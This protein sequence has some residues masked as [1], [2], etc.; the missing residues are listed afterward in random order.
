[1]LRRFLALTV[2]ALAA[3]CQAEQDQPE[4]NGRDSGSAG[5]KTAKKAA[6]KAARYRVWGRVTSEDG[7]PVKGAHI[8]LAWTSMQIDHPTTTTDGNG[9]YRFDGVDISG[10]ILA[11]QAEGYAPD[12]EHL[13]RPKDAKIDFKL[14]P[15]NWL[16]GRIVNGKDEPISGVKVFVMIRSPKIL[17]CDRMYCYLRSTP[18]TDE[19][20][21][22]RLQDLPAE[23]VF[24]SI[25]HEG[26]SSVERRG[27]A[28][29]RKDNLIQLL[30][31]G[32][33]S[34]RVVRAAD[35]KP[36]QQFKVRLGFPEQRLRGDRCMSIPSELCSPGS[37]FDSPDGT[38]VVP[39]LKTGDTVRVV[40]DAPGFQRQADDRVKVQPKSGTDREAAAA[41]RLRRAVDFEGV[42]GDAQTGKGLDDVEVVLLDAGARAAGQMSWPEGRDRERNHPVSA[43]TDA[44][45][46]FRIEVAPV[47]RGVV[48]LWKKG[49]ARTLLRDVDTSRSL[50]ARLAK[51]ATI[52]GK[53]KG[54]AGE[55]LADARA[56][57]T[58]LDQRI[59]FGDVSTDEAGNFE[60]TCL[61][62]GRYQV[63]LSH[64]YE[65][66]RS[67][68]AVVSTGQ[69]YT[70]DW[71]R[72]G[73]VKVSGIVTLR[74]APAPG[75]NV[76]L[77]SIDGSELAASGETGDDGRFRLSAY[78]VGKYR[79]WFCKGDWA[80]PG[81]IYI[82]KPVTLKT[83]ENQFD[84]VL[85]GASVSGRVIVGATGEPAAKLEVRAY[86][87]RTDEE[88]FGEGNWSEQRLE[89]SWYPMGHASTDA[90][91][92]FRMSNMAAGEWLIAVK[93]KESLIPSRPF[94]LKQDEV[95]EGLALELPRTGSARIAVLDAET[96]EAI[97]DVFLECANEWGF[98]S[99]PSD[100]EASPRCSGG[101]PADG[102]GLSDEGEARFS[103]LPP[104][105]Y[106]VHASWS[107]VYLQ[108]SLQFEVEAGEATRATLRLRQGGR[109][110]FRLLETSEDRM[111]GIPWIGFRI[112]RSDDG[113]PALLDARGPTLG[114]VRFP[115]AEG[116]RGPHVPLLP[117]RYQVEAVL[118]RESRSGVIS[119]TRNIWHTNTVVEVK[120]GQD[121]VIEVPW[122]ESIRDRHDDERR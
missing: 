3:V 103:G 49:F 114:G 44:H 117:G 56:S 51:G 45:G 90:E 43:R 17:M 24:V 100:E 119:A 76:S 23:G 22:F 5:E 31:P 36:V 80:D 79:L 21:R 27:L 88:V 71:D 110:C 94:R 72:V 9:E 2:I 53:A 107:P 102:W 113:R 106:T 8:S 97:T 25:S 13:Q 118:R 75:V 111:P 67:H 74:A 30:P 78:R 69:E 105:R 73:P 92:R 10:D 82:R 61:P 77:N 18:T 58:H 14:K 66:V 38:F 52:R 41:F 63:H 99:Y 26:Y 12:F 122:T 6:R 15:G 83:G 62:A 64:G 48:L 109:I 54:E 87:R 116:I 70:V 7:K 20:G 112:R 85:P 108:T 47:R 40:V 16:E 32:Q 68:E 42:I 4:A 91:G 33:I 65:C 86:L 101:C 55:I 11:V 1:M 81:T 95:R 89:R 57:C 46:R 121:T 35:G 115:R 39:G 93:G 84:L 29:G 120:S 96:G 104:G 60:F 34:G 50:R 59:S 28:V 19:E 37:S 98:V